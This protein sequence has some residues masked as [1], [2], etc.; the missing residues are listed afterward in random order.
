MV[1]ALN[2]GKSDY[3]MSWPQL[4]QMY[5]EGWEIGSHSFTHPD[6]RSADEETVRYELSQSKSMLQAH[7]IQNVEN[8]AYP[9]SYYSLDVLNVISEYYRSARTSVAQT[10]FHVNPQHIQPYEL[11]AYEARL[12]VENVTDAYKYVDQAKK[13]GRW[14]IF[15]LHEF[16]DS[17]QSKKGLTKEI[18]NIEAMKML[19]DYIQAKNI[20][21]MTT[22]QALDYYIGRK[23]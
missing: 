23:K 14:L 1:P 13:E 3:Y 11:S 19:I 2:V 20:R 17:R 5:N 12:T 10:G 15:I 18:T 9:Y 8:F 16:I 7:G 22:D 21:I 4:L 6:L